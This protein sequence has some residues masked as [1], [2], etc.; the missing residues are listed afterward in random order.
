MKTGVRFELLHIAYRQYVMG[1]AGQTWRMARHNT[2]DGPPIRPAPSHVTR[3]RDDSMRDDGQ[4]QGNL[5]SVNN[6]SLETLRC[7]VHQT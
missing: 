1:A 3:A 2:M 7:G 6:N 4:Q 5:L